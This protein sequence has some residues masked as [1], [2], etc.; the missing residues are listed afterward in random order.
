MFIFQ[1]T[2]GLGN[3]L[4]QY[5]QSK[6]FER[7]LNIKFV[8][9]KYFYKEKIPHLDKRKPELDYIHNVQF[10]GIPHKFSINITQFLLETKDILLYK[11]VLFLEKRKFLILNDKTIKLCWFF[12]KFFDDIIFTGYWQNQ[13][14]REMHRKFLLEF[15]PK[16]HNQLGIELT[17]ICQKIEKDSIGVFVRRGDYVKLG[18]AK[19][20]SYYKNAI[21]KLVDKNNLTI[22]AIF[23]DDIEWCKANLIIDKHKVFILEIIKV[24]L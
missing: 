13:F 6:N 11:F 4:F 12:R 14:K 16:I 19:N 2:G 22:I 20:A 3:Q 7:K 8:Y 24:A 15:R 18:I 5:L 9:S 21:L 10:L 23:S 1:I 17:K